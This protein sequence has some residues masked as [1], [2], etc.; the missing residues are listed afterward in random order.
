MQMNDR[1]YTLTFEDRGSYLYV[2]ITG[3][4][5]YE[6][7]MAYWPA[8]AD[9]VERKGFKR[10][11][12]HENLQGTV[13]EGE[14]YEIMMNLRGSALMGIR[15]AFYDEN[16]QDIPLNSLGQL[17]ANNRGGQV[18]LFQNLQAA[19]EWISRPD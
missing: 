6:A 13:T 8:I 2:R 12:V 4:D 11:L 18:H 5:S 15:I 17:I 10:L 14:I 7:S 3:R 19:E 16:R 9:E 1:E